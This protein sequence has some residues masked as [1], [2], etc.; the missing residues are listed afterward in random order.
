MSSSGNGGGIV[1]PALVSS[2]CTDVLQKIP[3]AS[4]CVGGPREELEL[5][6]VSSR[7]RF[8]TDWYSERDWYPF[9]STKV[10][11]VSNLLS[12]SWNLTLSATAAERKLYS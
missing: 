8:E 3:C 12:G 7:F 9:R 1:Y 5:F 11:A 4:L 2:L 10:F 6:S